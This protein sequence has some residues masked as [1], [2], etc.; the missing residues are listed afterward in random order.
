MA[1]GSP[2]IP[3]ED[4]VVRYQNTHNKNVV[5][6]LFKRHSL[7]CY[8]V[9]H[10]YLQNQDAAKD[11]AMAVFEKLFDDLLKHH[12]QNFKSWLY[13]VCKNH[14]LMQLRKPQREVHV[15]ELAEESEDF[16]VKFNGL[17]H[18]DNV[19]ED[20]EQKLQALE[21]ALQQLNPKQRQ[22][23]ELFYLQQKS[24]DEVSRQT[25]YTTNEVKS[26]IQNGKRNLKNTLAQNGIL[27]GWAIA[28]WILHTA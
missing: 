2:H 18:H 20:R 8:T 28:I 7:M 5:G 23:I 24:Y 16:F 10:K 1:F 12:P 27:F 4:L 22:C 6:E 26:Y 13:T 19:G 17:V 21:S 3:D 25:G 11:A 14:C 15:E 9:C